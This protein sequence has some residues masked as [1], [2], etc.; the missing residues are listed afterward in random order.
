MN[1]TRFPKE[2]HLPDWAL[3]DNK[4]TKGDRVDI[5]HSECVSVVLVIQ[6]AMRMRHIVNCGLS[7][8]YNSFFHIISQKVCISKKLLTIRCV[9]WF[10]LQPSFLNVYHSGKN[11]ARYDKNYSVNPLKPKRRP[12]YLKPQSV[13]RCKHFSSRY[14]KTTSW[15]YIGQHSLFVLR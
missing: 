2:D 7:V 13:P 14:K 15:R 9:F 5:T 4:V 10:F 6:H 11:S 3:R 8:R 1:H 12:L